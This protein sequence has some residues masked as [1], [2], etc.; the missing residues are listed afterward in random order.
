M[1]V[2]RACNGEWWRTA[3]DLALEQEMERDPLFRLDD[4]HDLTKEQMRE[5]TM[6]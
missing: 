1:Q 6:A 2:S 3:A 5:R 4:I